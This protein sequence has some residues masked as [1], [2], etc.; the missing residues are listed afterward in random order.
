MA[1]WALGMFIATV[2]G[3]AVSAAGLWALF[4]NLSLQR[5]ATNAATTA[6]GLQ[7]KQFLAERRPWVAITGYEIQE[8]K[9]RDG[10]LHIGIDI[11]LT[12]M[13]QT[14]ALYVDVKCKAVAAL[15]PSTIIGMQDEIR[16][17]A[18]KVRPEFS[19]TIFQNTP[20]SQSGSAVVTNRDM[21]VERDKQRRETP[22]Q[23]SDPKVRMM[24]AFYGVVRYESPHGGDV[25]TS[26]FLISVTLG[27][28]PH[29]ELHPEALIDQRLNT[30]YLRLNVHGLGWSAD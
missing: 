6:L 9:L 29:F 15:D 27:G 24:P 18:K 26:G 23:V 4:R 25:H 30:A 20:M 3:L 14:P 16:A 7:Q 13:G 11:A 22:E 8:W 12:N 1:E 2:V 21:L 19:M 10:G 17:E 5:Q 28:K